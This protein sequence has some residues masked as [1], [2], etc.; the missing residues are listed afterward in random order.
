[1]LLTLIQPC[2]PSEVDT[3]TFT[4]RIHTQKCAS[5]GAQ[6]RKLSLMHGQ[7]RLKDTDDT[8]RSTEALERTH[9]LN[10]DA[11]IDAMSTDTDRGGQ[12]CARMDVPG[13]THLHR[14]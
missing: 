8:Q 11:C 3:N 5:R 7:G 4:G 13:C 12:I 10:S 9:T 2:L 14:Y 1:M 6:P